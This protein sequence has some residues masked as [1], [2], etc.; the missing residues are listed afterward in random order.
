MASDFGAATPMETLPI[1]DLAP[2]LDGDIGTVAAALHDAA[3]EIG[4]FYVANHGIPQA[5]MEGAFAAARLFFDMPDAIKQSVA[6]GTD[7]RGWMGPGMSKLAGARTADRKEVFFW[8]REIA[9]N[10]PDIGKPMVAPNRWPDARVPCLREGIEPYYRAVCAVGAML[11]RAVAVSLG[12]APDA[13]AP[14][15]TRP[16]ARGQAVH[17]PP[18]RPEDAD[19]ERYGVAPHTDFGVLTL[20]LQDQ[21]GGLQVRR[22]DGVWIE[23][24]PIPGTLVCNI[25]D[26]LQRWSNDRFVSTVHRVINRTSGAR[27]SIPVFYDPNTDAIIDPRAFLSPGEAPRHA[28]ITPGE[29]ITARNRQSFSQYAKDDRDEA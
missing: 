26:L 7:Q 2:L 25:G 29:H 11:M 6:I 27:H 24:P 10:D 4:F 20:L 17:Y 13:F 21:S 15:Y 23:A 16:L 12:G 8:G 19:E 1:I 9:A 18:A 22:R 3:T 14:H 5:T 28:P